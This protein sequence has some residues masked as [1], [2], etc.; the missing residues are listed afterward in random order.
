ML[1]ERPRTSGSSPPAVAISPSHL[2]M[3]L[4]SLDIMR[5]TVAVGQAASWRTCTQAE[6]AESAT[7][8]R[9]CITSA[10]HC[11]LPIEEEALMKLCA[12]LAP[13]LGFAAAITRRRPRPVERRREPQRLGRGR[14]A[15]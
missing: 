9:G 5:R 2:Q 8:H 15:G 4:D 6:Y 1:F 3:L 11:L 13:L 7:S 10:L 14:L 12:L